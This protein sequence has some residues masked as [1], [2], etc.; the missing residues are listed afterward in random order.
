M[1]LKSSYL[2]GDT[3][4]TKVSDS[5]VLLC[6]DF[7]EQGEHGSTTVAAP[8]LAKGSWIRYLVPNGV[9]KQMAERI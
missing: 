7:C 6:A 9:Q 3:V 4:Q 8:D 1:H 5:L 2:N